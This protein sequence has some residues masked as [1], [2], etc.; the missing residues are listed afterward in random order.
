MEVRMA[1]KSPLVKRY[2]V[3]LEP[4]ERDRLEAMLRKANT[5]RRL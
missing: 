5:G 4:E 1:G 3:R 2:V